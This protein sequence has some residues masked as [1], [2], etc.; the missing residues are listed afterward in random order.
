MA[1][2]ESGESEVKWKKTCGGIAKDSS[3]GRYVQRTKGAE[4]PKSR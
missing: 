1:S 4:F 2:F 3:S